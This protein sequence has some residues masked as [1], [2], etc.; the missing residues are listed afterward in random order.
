MEKRVIGGILNVP[1]IIRL[2]MAAAKFMEH[3]HNTYDIKAISM[4]GILGF[5]FF[6]A[7]I[8]LIRTT[9]DLPS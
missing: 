5:I 6:I 9:E 8:G 3:S 2:E 1:G 7:G 4:Y